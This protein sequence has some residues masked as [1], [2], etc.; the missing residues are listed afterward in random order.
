M[1]FTTTDNS[2]FDERCKVLCLS[3]FVTAVPNF[4]FIFQ[5][6]LAIGY[7]GPLLENTPHLK[8]FWW[9]VW[10]QMRPRTSWGKHQDLQKGHL[11]WKVSY[12]IIAKKLDKVPNSNQNR[13]N[14][15]EILD[16]V[17]RYLKWPYILL[18]GSNNPYWNFDI[19]YFH[20][21]F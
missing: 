15:L 7:F 14:T 6:R 17:K 13:E 9:K 10:N 5:N 21:V 19:L 16:I 3:Y 8:N 18:T 11:L 1:R 4:Y 20:E 12:V 2:N